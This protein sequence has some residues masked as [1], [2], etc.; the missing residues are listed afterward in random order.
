MERYM[1]RVEEEE[2]ATGDANSNSS[3]GSA[4]VVDGGY[5]RRKEAVSG[6]S[7]RPVLDEATRRELNERFVAEETARAAAADADP[8]GAEAKMRATREALPIAKIRTELCEALRTNRVV[9][10]SGGTGSGKSTQCP[11][12]ILEDAI[13]RGLGPDTRI[14]VTQPRR[15]AA[16]SVAERVAAA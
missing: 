8:A 14:I 12:Y 7:R 9:V 4:D 10:V 2:E 11:Q 6:A 3:D 16:V 13:A 5:R 1:L 15:I